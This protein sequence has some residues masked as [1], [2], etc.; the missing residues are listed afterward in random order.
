MAAV[1]RI[2][3]KSASEIILIH[4]LTKSDVKLETA[5]ELS[6]EVN[7]SLMTFIYVYVYIP[8]YVNCQ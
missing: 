6:L 1:L 5:T 3:E 7:D 2:P 8:A 4:K